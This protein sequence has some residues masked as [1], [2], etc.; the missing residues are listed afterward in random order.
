[1]KLS[2]KTLAAGVA[3]AAGSLSAHAALYDIS[4][5]TIFD[6]LDSGSVVDTKSFTLLARV[7]GTLQGNLNTVLVN[8]VV[9]WNINGHTYSGNQIGSFT[10]YF[11][12]SNTL[13][14]AAV[15]TLDGSAIDFVVASATAYVEFS[16]V[17]PNG[18]HY[19]DFAYPTAEYGFAYDP[20]NGT[21]LNASWSMTEYVAPAVVPEPATALLMLAG[22]PML[23]A[24][25]RRQRS[26]AAAN[27]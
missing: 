23:G 21:P 4:Y 13:D 5:E 20:S 15:F 10:N 1:M 27:A 14:H 7:E 19:A 2:L 22:V 8:N 11:T 25:R 3:L 18:A 6:I 17:S 26:V 9:S 16:S 24:A 12:N